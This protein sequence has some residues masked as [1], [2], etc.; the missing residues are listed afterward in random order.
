MS[1]LFV[2]GVGMTRFG[3]HP[4]KS[5]YDLASE[6]VR[7]ALEDAGAIGSDVQAVYWGG[8]TQGA[9]QG[10]HCVPFQWWRSR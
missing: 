7:I 10:Q 5:V 6:A 3:R 2:A 8:A 9:L 1:D 4:D